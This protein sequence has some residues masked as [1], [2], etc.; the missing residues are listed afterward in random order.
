MTFGLL[1]GVAEPA[2]QAALPMRLRSSQ[3][4]A[5][6]AGTAL[7]IPAPPPPPPTPSNQPDTYPRL[8]R[9]ISADLVRRV[10]WVHVNQIKYCYQQA[11]FK[12]PGLAGRLVVNFQISPLGQV[13]EL[14]VRETTLQSPPLEACITDTMRTWEF[15]PT[16]HYAGVTEINYPF[17]LRTKV[18]EPPLGV[19][20]SDAELERIGI[21]R[22]PEPPAVDI[23][24]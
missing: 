5:I 18:V 21:F 20:V 17:V 14:A 11:L 7:T 3:A 13:L 12:Q 23:L 8:G 9:G 4:P 6:P 2:S 16:P 10:V 22:D 19:Q 1:A 15:P 24:F